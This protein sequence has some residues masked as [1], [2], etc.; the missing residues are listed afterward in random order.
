MRK[1]NYK[2]I[3]F[4]ITGLSGSGKTGIAKNIFKNIEKEY[5]PTLHL[6]GDEARKMLRVKGYTKQQRYKI[7]LKYHKV[8]KKISDQGVNVLFDVV[9]LIEEIRKKNRKYLKNYLEIFIKADSKILIKKKKKF[10]YRVK[11]KN[12]WGIDIK[13]EFPKK[14]EIVINNNFKKTISQLSNSLLK[15]IRNYY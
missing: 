8:C 11:T 9:C 2:G 14:P 4:W 10:F 7:G 5:G 3:V 15:K 6:S 12:V 1:K 13:P